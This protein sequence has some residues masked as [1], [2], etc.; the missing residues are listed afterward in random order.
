MQYAAAERA[1]DARAGVIASVMANANRGRQRRPITPADFF[2]S[3]K[4][5]AP[6]VMTPAEMRAAVT[7]HF[8]LT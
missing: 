5:S 2:P 4:P 6:R 7:A 1:L 8:G 3:L